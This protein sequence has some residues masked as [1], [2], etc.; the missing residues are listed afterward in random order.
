VWPESGA[1]L[2]DSWVYGT[3]IKIEEKPLSNP[4]VPSFPEF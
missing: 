2:N 1:D 4:S 3:G